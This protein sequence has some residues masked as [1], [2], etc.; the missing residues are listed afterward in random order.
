MISEIFCRAKWLQ[1]EVTCRT[2]FLFLFEALTLCAAPVIFVFASNNYLKVTCALTEVILCCFFKALNIRFF[3]RGI[4][5]GFNCRQNDVL[6]S[7]LLEMLL[8]FLRLVI[9]L[10]C[11]FPS[12]LMLLFGFLA[13]KDRVP[14][15]S[16]AIIFSFCA[17][18]AGLGVFFY[19]RFSALLFLSPYIFLFSP[20]EG[21]LFSI[22]Q[23]AE[24]FDESVACLV[25]LKRRFAFS[26]M[27]CLLVFP[28]ISVA[29]IKKRS[30]ALLA[31]R[32]L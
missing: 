28:L 8:L 25:K 27:L 29:G 16:V 2:F 3:T 21:M 23:S 11:F 14:M 19:N 6:L 30:L 12:L 22:L 26:N 7:V 15:L 9:M 24:K 1:R 18:L 10:L 31:Y 13:I 32:L 20:G 17:S 5:A 4:A